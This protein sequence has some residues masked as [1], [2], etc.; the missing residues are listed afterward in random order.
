MIAPDARVR[1]TWPNAF[2]LVLFLALGTVFFRKPFDLDYCWQIRTGERI[3]DS[4]R[5]RQP[6]P[7][8]YTI[9]GK[10]VPDHEW[11]YESML[12]LVWRGLGDGGLRLAR[13]LLYLA[14]VV[15]LAWQLRQRGVPDYVV[16]IAVLIVLF[17]FLFFARLRPMV[18]STIGL[19]LVAGWL[20]DHCTGRQRLDW[21][22]PVTTLVWG[23]LHPAVIMGQALILGA[24]LWEWLVVLWSRQ[25]ESG[26]TNESG[27]PRARDPVSLTKWGLISLGTTL[28]APDPWAR[29]TYPFASELRD[30]A[31][32]LFVETRS[33]WH[34][35]ASSPALWLV[36]ALAFFLGTVLVLRR[37]EVFGWEWALLF[38]VTGL[39]LLA[40]RAIC[41][42]L[43]IVSVLA[44]PQVGP[45]LAE[46]A[47]ARPPRHVLALILRLDRVCKRVFSGS[48]LRIQP[49]WAGCGIA[50]ILLFGL[51]PWGE[52]LPNRE[53]AEW[54]SG[55]A[56]W[57]AAG[58][59]PGQGPW[60]IF[61]GQNEGSYLI[62]RLSGKARVYTDTRAFYY[63]GQ[64]LRDSY[65]LPR[66]QGH[67]PE[68]VDHALQNETEY[69]LIPKQGGLWQ[70]I[71]A[72]AAE[73]LY[74]DS[75]FV[76]LSAG[77]MRDATWRFRSTTD[78][79]QDPSA[80]SGPP[81]SPRS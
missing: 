28:I 39:A 15:I 8:S 67:W 42:W 54:P 6:D 2:T 12:A 37:R 60:N 81:R 7:F 66:G 65:H 68:L 25:A 19:Q 24:I 63:S 26:K 61:A 46:A 55:A 17:V 57:I 32:A 75:Q 74:Q 48:L 69:F 52:R 22:L 59:L 5:L 56:D 49:P 77:Q 10:E 1:L 64:L 80:R 11:L 79:S 34:Y 71:E 13:V 23:N 38:G 36:L 33:P 27:K 41:D 53:A 70:Q 31:Q 9:A 50:A 45:L 76:I 51:W 44:L 40:V 21:K 14:P 47:R 30:P 35:L 43:V 16:T 78:P 3:L 73:P 58:H 62:W 18:C 72:H 29:L 20:H 4:G